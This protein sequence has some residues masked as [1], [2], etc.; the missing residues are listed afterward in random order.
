MD[1][2]GENLPPLLKGWSDQV[3]QNWN[4]LGLLNITKN[5][6]K[7]KGNNR[8]ITRNSVFSVNKDKGS[9][10]SNRAQQKMDLRQ[11]LYWQ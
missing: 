10:K 9:K 8:P 11:M 6:N 4:P 5:L 7:E 3:L 1:P 2:I